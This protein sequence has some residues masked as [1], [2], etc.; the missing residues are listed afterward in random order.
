MKRSIMGLKGCIAIVFSLVF[1][2]SAWAQGPA[3]QAATGST[4]SAAAGV[5]ADD[6][7]PFIEPTVVNE[8]AGQ[9]VLFD[10]THGQ[11]AGAADWVI[12]GG[13][14]DFGQ[15]LADD[16]YYVKELR[17]KTPITY[18]DLKDY[19]VFVIGEANIPYKTG[20][21]QAMKEYVN[22]GGSIFFIADHYNADRN[23]NRWDA[24]EVFNGYRRGAYANPAKGMTDEEASSAA[25]QNV[26]SSDWLS[27]NFGVR[28]RYNALADITADNIVAPSESFGI[29]QGVNAVAMHA[30]STLAITNPHQ[31]KGIVYLPKTDASWSFAVDQGVYDGGGTAEGPFVAISKSGAG[32]AAFIGDSSPVEDASP[33]Y[34][35]EDTGDRKTTYDGFKEQNDGTLL[36]NT[37]EW[38]SK[39]ESYTSLD[40]KVTLDQPTQLHDF[41]TPEDSTEPQPEPWAA[42]D[43]GYK[44]Y[45]TSTFKPG[46]YGSTQAALNPT[47]SFVHQD[48]LPS[49]ERVFQIR[50]TADGF[51]PNL[52]EDGYKVGLYL[53]GGEQIGEF[54]SDPNTWTENYGYSTPFSM[55]ADKNGHA[56]KDIYVKIK[57]DKLGDASL[58][59]KQG[60]KTLTT[61][62]VTVSDVDAEPLPDDPGN[63]VKEGTMNEIR[64]MD[65]GQTVKAK[66]TITTEP[67]IF[68]GEGFYMQDKTGGIYVFQSA[69]GYHA[70]DQITITATLDSYN[71]ELELTQPTITDV[72]SGTVPDPAEAEAVTADNQ[73]QL[74]TVKNVKISDV[75]KA[76][77]FGTIEMTGDAGN[78]PFVIR[79]DN[80]TGLDYDHFSY[81]NGDVLNVTGVSSIFKGAYQLKPR[82]KDDLEYADKQPPVTE[83]SVNCDKLSNGSCFEKATVTLK[84]TDEAS[85]VAKTEYRMDSGDWSSY[86]SPIVIEEEGHHTVEFKSV[87]AAGN[88]EATKTVNIDLT[89]ATMAHLFKKI[90]SI[91]DAPHGMKVSLLAHFAAIDLH[92]KLAHKFGMDT[93]KGQ[94][95]WAM[96]QKGL[97][98]EIKRLEHLKKH[99]T[100]EDYN[101]LM[102]YFEALAKQ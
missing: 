13:F 37:I 31:A 29:T 8:H 75:H 88:T 61:E 28:F 9:K 73:G 32:K 52:S 34:L 86:S 91:Q 59:L 36:V 95:E 10:N 67:G 33:K 69:S 62:S 2:F 56:T 85:G 20:E 22:N 4:V 96:R 87:D 93:K 6:P 49:N 84:A 11:T 35:R 19:D 30:G 79:V 76:D 18:D 53:P 12:N 7:A 70:G 24:S 97:E 63:T 27:E 42:P 65:A 57:A 71:G 40:G 41:E 98:K 102:M 5:T 100:K 60:S 1:S 92:D 44:W 51:T 55:T 46:S 48:Q 72:S 89:K 39:D 68:G 54:S 74:I 83:A 38:L 50:V 90:L 78:G 14:S 58:R 17:K 3:A 26:A 66:G 101:D 15:A 80:R 64:Q 25:M 82:G 94:K 21:Q 16:G 81:K 77:N 23:K 47:Y 45:D 99:F 43:P